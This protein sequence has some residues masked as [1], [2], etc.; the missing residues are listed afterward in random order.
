MGDH[1]QT[2]NGDH[3]GGTPEEVWF[4]LSLK[5]RFDYLL[6]I[7]GMV[8]SAGW[9]S[10]VCYEFEKAPSFNF[11]YLWRIIMQIVWGTWIDTREKCYD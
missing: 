5:T 11:I 8:N 9:D 7:S 3:G 4:L 10:P 6:L 1:G 2:L